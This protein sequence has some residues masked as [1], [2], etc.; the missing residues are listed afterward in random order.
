[1]KMDIKPIVGFALLWLM[2]VECCAQA[3]DCRCAKKWIEVTICSDKELKEKDEE[4]K[5]TLGRLSEGKKI[6]DIASEQ[7]RWEVQVR[8]VCGDKDCLIRVYGDRLQALFSD[9]QLYLFYRDVNSIRE[10]GV[11]KNGGTRISDFKISKYAKS[12]YCKSGVYP[13]SGPVF[14]GFKASEI[15]GRGKESSELCTRL[16][17]YIKKNYMCTIDLQPV[18]SWMSDRAGHYLDAPAL[19]IVPVLPGL[20][21]DAW[22]STKNNTTFLTYLVDIDNDGSIDVLRKHE[23]FFGGGQNDGLCIAYGG[24][25]YECFRD[26][27]LELRLIRPILLNDRNYL[28]TYS[29]ID[30]EVY[31]ENKQYGRFINIPTK[32]SFELLSLRRSQDGR[33]SRET[34]CHFDLLGGDK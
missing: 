7:S 30:D 34:I 3:I 4:L 10:E 20:E 8:D 13:S 14:S 2:S 6:S 1:M 27:K 16:A 28:L 21:I 11:A 33:L 29:T 12:N 18:V 24:G 31:V 22:L 9:R 19:S 25:G 26:E 15:R 23:F 32:R 5:W 17:S